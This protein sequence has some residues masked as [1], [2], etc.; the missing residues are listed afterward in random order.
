MTLPSNLTHIHST[1]I[2]ILEIGTTGNRY[3]CHC[4]S[5]GQRSGR[6]H[7]PP[8]SSSSSHVP[9]RQ[10]P[11]GILHGAKPSGILHDVDGVMQFFG[12]LQVRLA[13]LDERE[14]LP[15][16]GA[17][18]PEDYDW[19][20]FHAGG[21]G[22]GGGGAA[23]GKGFHGGGGGG[24]GLPEDCERQGFHGVGGGDDGGGGAVGRKRFHPAGGGGGG[25][26]GAV[27]G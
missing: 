3:S 6:F 14:A 23:G 20:G 26:G 22:G 9:V 12:N 5:R 21:G 18:L 10:H 15:G 17:D 19:E 24:G 4:P 16:E 1:H 2:C 11:P 25:G 7:F 13:G 27:R 8:Y